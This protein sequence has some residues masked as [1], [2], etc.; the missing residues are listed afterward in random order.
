[1]IWFFE[2]ESESLRVETRY[3]NDTSEFVA[4]VRYADGREQTH[5]FTKMDEFRAWLV[6]FE[7]SLEADHWVSQGG[8]SFLPNGWPD[9]RLM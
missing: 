8:P 4:I 6:A 2:R 5:R 3:D 1:M 7:Q 9:E